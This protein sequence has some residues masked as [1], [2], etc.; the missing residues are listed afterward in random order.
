[1]THPIT[2]TPDWLHGCEAGRA[3]MCLPAVP[4]QPEDTRP[5]FKSQ[6]VNESTADKCLNEMF[7]RSSIPSEDGRTQR[8]SV[9]SG[10]AGR[11]TKGSSE[12][13]LF[14]KNRPGCLSDTCDVETE[15]TPQKKILQSAVRISLRYQSV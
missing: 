8:L 12:I 11:E 10:P 9:S 3:A 13:L 2:N 5:R 7:E 4:T 14:F 15:V 6:T 1:M